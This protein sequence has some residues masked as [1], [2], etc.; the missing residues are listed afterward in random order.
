V[1]FFANK[2]SNVASDEHGGSLRI[3]HYIDLFLM[4]VGAIFV[5]MGVSIQDGKVISVGVIVI[6]VMIS[7]L[8]RGKRKRR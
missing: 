7:N 2:L 8:L 6:I 4:F 5:I 3:T 1:K